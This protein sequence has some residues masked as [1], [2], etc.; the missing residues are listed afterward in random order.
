VDKLDPEDPR[1][2]RLVFSGQLSQVEEGDE[3]QFATTALFERHPAMKT[4]PVDHNWHVY[5]INIT[6]IWLID[7][8]GGG[9]THKSNGFC[10]ILANFLS[11][12]SKIGS[13]VTVEEYYDVKYPLIE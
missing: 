4:W 12:T 5:K 11:S 9:M 7:I 3:L 6:D 8:Y 10:H 2:V 13:I 1:C